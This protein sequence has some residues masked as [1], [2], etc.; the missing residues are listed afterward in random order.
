MVHLMRTVSPLCTFQICGYSQRSYWL[1]SHRVSS[2]VKNTGLDRLED[3]PTALRYSAVQGDCFLL[4][5]QRLCIHQMYISL[6]EE[7][8]PCA[9]RIDSTIQDRPCQGNFVP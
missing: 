2:L 4:I 1:T 6:L 9:L 7:G 8:S 5:A 3:G